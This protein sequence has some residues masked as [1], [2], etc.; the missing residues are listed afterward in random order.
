MK[1]NL[2]KKI[3]KSDKI[4]SYNDLLKYPIQEQIHVKFKKAYVLSFDI[5]RVFYKEAAVLK[6]QKLKAKYQRK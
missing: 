6:V 3:Y 1:E 5:I 2:N 4:I